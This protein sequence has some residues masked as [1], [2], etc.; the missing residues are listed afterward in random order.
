M[1]A[2]REDEEVLS[3]CPSFSVDSTMAVML[4]SRN[5][6]PAPNT[7]YL[8]HHLPQY[9]LFQQEKIPFSP[10]FKALSWMTGLVVR[11]TTSMGVCDIKRSWPWE[12]VHVRKQVEVRLGE[13]SFQALL[14]KHEAQPSA[15]SRGNSVMVSSPETIGKPPA[16]PSST[17]ARLICS[18]SMPEPHKFLPCFPTLLLPHSEPFTPNSGSGIHVWKAPNLY[19]EF[20]YSLRE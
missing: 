7:H 4:C 1:K 13:T 6:P 5:V 20:S 3:S 16:S 19:L 18:S 11:G 15:P 8:H 10:L 2:K 17:Q 14:I 9:Q 12:G